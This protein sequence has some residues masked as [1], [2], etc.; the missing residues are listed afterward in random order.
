MTRVLV[1]DEQPLMLKGGLALF[2]DAGVEGVVQAQSVADGIRLYR[3]LRP[4]VLIVE[5]AMQ[6][7]VFSGLSLIQR[8][9][10]QDWNIPILVYSVHRDPIVVSRALEVGA[11][12]YLLKHTSPLEMLT[13]LK[14]VREGKPFISPDLASEVAVFA[15][16][17][18]SNPLRH[19][20]VRELQALEFV[21][22]GTPYRVIAAHLHVSYKTVANTCAKLKAKLGVVTLAELRCTAI[23]H[24]SSATTQQMD[25]VDSIDAVSSSV[26]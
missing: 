15:I 20:T 14:K 23:K 22:D 19:L 1:I 4:D 6:T 18:T 11:T 16:R 25:R 3:K 10:L 9:R 8:I 7:G 12:G 17:G 24:L 21:A 13:A 26:T 5:L 2:K